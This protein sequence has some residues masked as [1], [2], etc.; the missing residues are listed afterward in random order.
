MKP[1]KLALYLGCTIQSE[2]YAYEMSVRETLPR[3]GVE[4]VEMEGASCCGYPIKN[5]SIPMWL[6]LSTRN[7]AIAS[8]LGLDILTLCNG[9]YMS[10]R[11]ARKALDED[12]NLRSR[13]AQLLEVEGLKYEGDVKVYHLLDALHDLVGVDR[14]KDAVER[15]LEGLRFATHYGCHVLRPSELGAP[16]DPEDPHKLEEL[17]E[18]LG[19]E[20]VDYPEKLDCCGAEL[21]ISYSDASLTMAGL[22]LKAVQRRNVDGL[23]VICPYCMKM[24]DAKQDAAKTTLGDPTIEVPVIYYTQ[25]L[26]LTMGID[27]DKLGLNL[28]L[29]PIDKLLGKIG[30]EGVE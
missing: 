30:G 7:L 21:A 1:L 19:A 2:Q 15:P 24:L 23:V 12:V 18:A 9:C 10:L 13:I 5:V 20:T 27:A 22:K 28:N 29:S 26:G 6:Y 4:L 25:L 16:D 8:Q 11:E 17:I 3:L 14:V